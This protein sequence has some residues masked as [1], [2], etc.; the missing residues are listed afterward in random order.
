MFASIRET[1]PTVGNRRKRSL[2]G[3]RSEKL[4]ASRER[5]K[6]VAIDTINH[7]LGFAGCAEP[8]RAAASL[9]LSATFPGNQAMRVPLSV[10]NIVEDINQCRNANCT[11]NHSP[12]ELRIVNKGGHASHGH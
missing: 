1:R 8:A 9:Q 7:D 5:A 3:I 10:Q 2:K 4:D 6:I 11:S 12:V